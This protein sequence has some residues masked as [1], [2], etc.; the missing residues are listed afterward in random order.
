MNLIDDLARQRC[1]RDT[2]KDGCASQSNRDHAL[3]EWCHPCLARRELGRP[4]DSA[5]RLCENC[6]EVMVE[7]NMAGG[8][9]TG[10]DTTGSQTC[11]APLHQPHLY[12]EELSR[13]SETRAHPNHRYDW[14][15]R[16]CLICTPETAEVAR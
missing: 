8:I 16:L 12:Y 14:Q 9:P 6:G 2:G 5:D 1:E 13:R 7:F 11:V 4:P 15:P 3:S 10:A